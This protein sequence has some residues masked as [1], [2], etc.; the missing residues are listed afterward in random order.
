[1]LR[2]YGRQR[3]RQALLDKFAGVLVAS[4]H[5]RDEYLRHGVAPE[6]LHVVPL[7]PPGQQPDGQPPT[8]RPRNGHVLMV[9]RLTEL[10]GGELLVESMSHARAGLSHPLTLTVAGDGP[11]CAAMEALARRRGVSARFYGWVSAPQRTRLMREADVLAMP[12]V[13]PEPF[14]LVGIEAGCVGLPAV[15]FAVG[16][17][18]EWLIAGV[19]GELAPGDRPRPRDLADALVRALVDEAHWH[20]LRRGAWETAHTFS[21]E[22]HLKRLIPLLAWAAHQ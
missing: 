13:W 10:K 19:S 11:R 21:I 5:M 22:A 2:Q 16:G 14:G 6:R 12:S 17:I 8:P 18:P 3:R 15:G 1:M 4:G 7:F 20:R 9:G